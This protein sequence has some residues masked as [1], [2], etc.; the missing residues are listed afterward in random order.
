MKAHIMKRQ[1]VAGINL[2]QL[3]NLAYQRNNYIELE[4]Y[5]RIL[6]SR[7][8]IDYILIDLVQTSLERYS[9]G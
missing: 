1:E 4:E 3:C 7:H 5:I 8:Q 2:S 9:Q 6:Y